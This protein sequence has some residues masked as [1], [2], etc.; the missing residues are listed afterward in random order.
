MY[1]Y[2]TNAPTN[3]IDQNGLDWVFVSSSVRSVTL[4]NA[5]IKPWAHYKFETQG[6]QCHKIT[7]VGLANTMQLATINDVMF[8]NNSTEGV[9][10]ADVMSLAGSL[11]G[12]V[13]GISEVFGASLDAAS[14]ITKFIDLAT[15]SGTSVPIK[16]VSSGTITQDAYTTQPSANLVSRYDEV[17][18]NY[19]CESSPVVLNTDWSYWEEILVYY[20]NL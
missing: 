8:Y 16:I 14:E 6:C 12:L 1:R 15:S 5:E 2:V 19:K 18:G 3:A 13:P 9:T 4:K 7:E 20:S 10:P 17:Y 11:A